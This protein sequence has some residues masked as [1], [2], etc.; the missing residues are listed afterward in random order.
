MAPSRL[1]VLFALLAGSSV[2]RGESPVDPGKPLSPEDGLKSIHVKDG[3]AVELVA[4]EPMVVDPVAVAWGPDAKLWVVEMADYPVGSPKGSRVRYL[5]DTNN[6]GKYDKSTVFLDGL[7]FPNGVLPWRNGVIVTAA[8]DIFYAED[9]DGDGKADKR[10]VLYTGFTEGNP[11]LRV[12]G[13]RWGLDNW[14]YLANGW[15][16]RGKV[17][18]V[19]TGKEVEVSGRD[20][21][22]RPDTGEI[23]A[24][25][26]MT[27]F[28]RERDDFGDW[29]GCD[30]AHPMWHFVLPE[31]Y[32]ARN[33]HVPPPDPREQLLKPFPPKVYAISKRARRYNAFDI[34]DHFQSACSAVV[35]RDELL[36]PRE[37]NPRHGFVCDPVHNLVH[38]TVLTESGVTF[39]AARAPDEQASEFFASTDNWCRPVMALTGPDGALWVVDMYRFM[40][41][42][43]E[44]LPEVGRKELSPHYRLGDD[45]G[46]IYRVVPKNQAA[47]QI[48]RMDRRN[49]IELCRAAMD[50]PS[51]WERDMAQMLLLWNKPR[52]GAEARGELSGVVY[53]SQNPLARLQAL[54]TLEGM[55]SV[56]PEVLVAALG[57]EH[58]AVRRQALR[59]AEKFENSPEVVQAALKLVEDPSP[60][61]QLQLAMSL[62][63]WHGPQVGRAVGVLAKRARDPY[64]AAAILSSA[65]NHFDFI[66]S[67]PTDVDDSPLYTGLLAMTTAQND[68]RRT[69]GLLDNLLKGGE[70]RTYTA[71]QMSTVSRWLDRPGADTFDT[72]ISHI[73][74]EPGERLRESFGRMCDS[75]SA[76]ASDGK[77]P[78][79]ARAAAIGLLLRRPNRTDA[80]LKLLSALL[81][82]QTPADVQRAAVTAAGRA[83]ADAAPPVLLKEWPGYSPAV[84]GAVVDV[85]LRS[86][87]SAACL[88]DAVEA[89][90]VTVADIDLPRRQRLLNYKDAAIKDRA[91]KLLAESAV[92][93]NRQK[94]L[95][96]WRPVMSMKG[97]AKSG[98]EVFRQNC[99][100]CHHLGDVGQEVGPN[101]E[102]VREWTGEAV[103][104][105]IL[106]PNRQTEPKFIAYTATTS[107]GETIYGVVASE[108]GNAVTMK[109][110]DGKEHP[111]LRSDLKSLVSSNRTLMPD[112]FE[113]SMTKQQMA[114]LL[115][116]LKAPERAQ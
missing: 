103:L 10:E 20:L 55:G 38:H 83:P 112:G 54:C 60:K 3:F 2:A 110:L 50:S 17:K 75:A 65:P 91:A 39:T 59:I 52:M 74:V 88:L 70:A 101:L 34:Q 51:G 90:Q 96:T 37:D 25:E 69:A 5:E 72:F 9:T 81:T 64:S 89:K 107:A 114:D 29:F 82:P 62:G 78:L 108:S 73:D 68:R 4:A 66:V 53:G 67:A 27:E 99:A 48:P 97:N 86:A 61:V 71:G 21:R 36:F 105:A 104:T 28:G 26:G 85:L 57:D 109:G 12:N 56:T 79:E 6:D 41:E 16:S 116:F 106:D 95:D 42:H 15:S 11:Q 47:R 40:V 49:T 43:P 46:R 94:V 63:E 23:E 92:T 113:S 115:E 7:K 93:S 8:P 32:T 111:V 35:Y 22:I 13:L 84:R 100:V 45:R 87:A 98:A 31:R 1:L 77:A 24:V 80:E 14:V 76:V 30:N 33:P 19:K 102:T 44:Y 18:S 58:W